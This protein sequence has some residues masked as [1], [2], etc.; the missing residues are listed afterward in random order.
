MSIMVHNILWLRPHRIITPEKK[1]S[2]IIYSMKNGWNDSHLLYK[3]FKCAMHSFL[4]FS[5]GFY[6]EHVILPSK[7]L[8][9]LSCYNSS[10]L[11]NTWKWII[12]QLRNSNINKLS[13]AFF[14]PVAWCCFHHHS[15]DITH[16]INNSFLL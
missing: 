1:I 3:L 7:I 16:Q 4:S 2:N 5:T 8:P 14:I 12:H 10:R 11:L 13:F 15:I 9:F 6:E